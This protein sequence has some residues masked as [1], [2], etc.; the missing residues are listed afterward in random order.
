M[1]CLAEKYTARNTTARTA[2]TSSMHMATNL[3]CNFRIMGQLPPFVENS[4]EKW[5]NVYFVENY[6]PSGASRQYPT[7]RMV[8][9]FTWERRCSS[10]FRRKEI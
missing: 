7:M 8:R 1:F 2:V 6:S 3:I 5:K 9:I 4:V 10:F